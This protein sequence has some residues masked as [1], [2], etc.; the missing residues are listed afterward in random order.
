MGESTEGMV[1]STSKLQAKIQALT[2]FDV[3]TD[4]NTYKSTFEITKGLASAYATMNDIDRA[5]LLELVAGGR[6]GRNVE[7]Y[8]YR[9]FLIAGTPLEPYTTIVEKSDYECLTT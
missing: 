7:K 8:L 3:M 9:I 2:G 1:D 4:E 5:A 6:L